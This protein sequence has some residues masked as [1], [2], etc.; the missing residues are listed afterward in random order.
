MKVFLA[1]GFA[2]RGADDYKAESE[3][4]RLFRSDGALRFR[5]R[6]MAY[7]LSTKDEYLDI[8]RP[9]AMAA[10]RDN[11]GKIDWSKS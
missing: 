9:S 7:T 5:H 8:Y 11:F 1:G 3:G 2:E 10:Y 4:N 6:L